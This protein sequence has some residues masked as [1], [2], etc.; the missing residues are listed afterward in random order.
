MARPL[1][2]KA[3]GG[4]GKACVP[5]N[6]AKPSVSVIGRLLGSRRQGWA[7][8]AELTYR[9][10]GFAELGG[11]VEGS[12]LFSLARAGLHFDTNV[13][14]GGAADPDEEEADGEVK[15]R[16][17]YDVTPWL[18]VGLD[19][20]F[21]YRL[22][23][24]QSLPGNRLGDAVGGPELLFSY[25]HFFVAAD[26]G[27]STVGIARGVGGTVLGTLGASVW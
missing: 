7:L 26:G 19:G 10:D 24:A 23:G 18:R 20:R 13:T 27:P 22:L 3:C 21:R 1:D 11:E 12:V 6:A 4:A 14:F 17:G 25:K 2:D 8:S 9:T 16:V 5:A 15:M